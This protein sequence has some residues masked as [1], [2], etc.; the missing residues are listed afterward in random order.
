MRGTADFGDL[1]AHRPLIDALIS[2][3]DAHHA[4]RIETERPALQRLPGERAADYEES[5]VTVTSS[6]GFSLRK[7]FFTVPFRLI[8]HRL[9]FRPY[10]DRLHLL[11]DATQLIV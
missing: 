6:G 10:D 11:I 1:P 3:K 4:S 5:L 9:R 2:R 8:G 7:V